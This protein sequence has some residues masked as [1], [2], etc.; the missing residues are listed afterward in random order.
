MARGDETRLLVQVPKRRMTTMMRKMTAAMMKKWSTKA[1][2][3]SLNAL[4]E[5][6]EK[7]TH[8]SRCKYR[9]SKMG[10]GRET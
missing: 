4:R 9:R 3:R 8:S 5:T 10:K 2:K 7:T 6:S 1:Y